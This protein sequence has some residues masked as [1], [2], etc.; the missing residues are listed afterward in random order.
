MIASATAV[1]SDAGASLDPST[2]TGDLVLVGV[3]GASVGISVCLRHDDISFVLYR[4][5]R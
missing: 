2:S 5:V 1:V 3:T 4:S